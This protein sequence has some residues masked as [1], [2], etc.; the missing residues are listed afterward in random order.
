MTTAKPNTVEQ[1]EHVIDICREV[2]QK[3]LHDYGASWRVMRPSSLTDQ[4]YIK[5]N[6]IRNIQMKGLSKVDEGVESEFIGVVNYGVIALIQLELGVA[7]TPKMETEEALR[8]YDLK[9]REAMSLMLD[10]NHDYGEAWRQMRVSSF[11]DLILTKVFR[12]K[13]IED[14]GG[15]TYIS[16]GVDANYMDMINY[17][18][19]AL[20]QLNG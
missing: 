3:K 19:F 12:T 10:K 14:L 11:A 5:A 18:I 6:R 1:F 13:E 9:I 2:F 20:I 17:A 4:L 8:L 7:D 15:D 16:E